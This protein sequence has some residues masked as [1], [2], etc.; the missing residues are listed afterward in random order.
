MMFNKGTPYD[1]WWTGQEFKEMR[2]EACAQ[3]LRVEAT[4][5]RELR[6]KHFDLAIAH[7]HDLCPLAMAEKVGVRRVGFSCV[8]VQLYICYNVLIYNSNYRSNF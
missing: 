7:F 3:M 1:L 4:A 2:V 8:F 5:L 6:D